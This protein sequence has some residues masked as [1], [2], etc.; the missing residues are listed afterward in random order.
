MYL[1][2]LIYASRARNIDEDAL[3]VILEKARKN[4]ERLDVTGVLLFNSSYFLQCLEGGRESVNFLYRTIL[5]DD[6]H[7]DP[8][9]LDYRTIDCRKFEKWRMAY[10][11][12]SV[13]R[14]DEILKCSVSSTFQPYNMSGEGAWQLLASIGSLSETQP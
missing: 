6:R 8:A 14:R 3:R 4:N 7:D 12:E 11:G 9:I 1:T 13:L 2:S 10:V 5:R